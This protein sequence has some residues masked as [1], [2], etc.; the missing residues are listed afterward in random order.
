MIFK[1]EVSTLG[2]SENS[3]LIH[4]TQSHSN[5]HTGRYIFFLPVERSI[6]TTSWDSK[7]WLQ[8]RRLLTS[9]SCGVNEVSRSRLLLGSLVGEESWATVME[10]TGC[11]WD[12]EDSLDQ[13][14]LTLLMYCILGLLKEKCLMDVLKVLLLLYFYIFFFTT[15][16]YSWGWDLTEK[17]LCFFFLFHFRKQGLCAA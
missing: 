17:C 12:L 15:A 14:R 13:A 10:V 3:E 11:H 7:K 2:G 5:F 9:A 1:A 6:D 4:F 8:F 16:C